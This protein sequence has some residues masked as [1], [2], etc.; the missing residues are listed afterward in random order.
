MEKQS[1]IICQETENDKC[2]TESSEAGGILGAQFLI[3]LMIILSLLVMRHMKNT[4]PI[5]QLVQEEIEKQISLEDLQ[6]TYE[7]LKEYL[8]EK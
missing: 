1:S 4:A 3:C 5:I 6:E 7:T 2:L 8:V